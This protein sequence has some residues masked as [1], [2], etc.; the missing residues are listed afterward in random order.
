MEELDQLRAH[1]ALI[2][3]LGS[4]PFLEPVSNPGITRTTLGLAWE[5]A[6]GSPGQPSI[7]AGSPGSRARPHP[8]P[9]AAAGNPGRPS[10]NAALPVPEGA[11]STEKPP[12]AQAP[13]GPGGTRIPPRPP[14]LGPLPSGLRAS[15]A[16]L[17]SESTNTMGAAGASP[18]TPLRRRCH[19]R[20]SFAHPGAAP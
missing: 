9:R 2:S 13:A 7:P 10:Y 5:G 4:Q 8:A 20:C 15:R 11:P 3:S 17:S 6:G 12:R 16:A 14:H 19:R 18:G 1:G